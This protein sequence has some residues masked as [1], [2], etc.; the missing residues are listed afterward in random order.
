[1]A[2]ATGNQ[3]TRTPFVCIL[4]LDLIAAGIS[5]RKNVHSRH[6]WCVQQQQHGPL[7]LPEQHMNT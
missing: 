4:G 3:T 2:V 1:M 5:F 7:L 6:A